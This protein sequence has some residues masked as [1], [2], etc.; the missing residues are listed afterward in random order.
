MASSKPIP[1]GPCE[2]GKVYTKADI[3]CYN[4]DEGLCSTCLSHHKKSKGTRDHKTIDINYK[5]FFQAIKTECDKHDKQLHLYC[6]SHLIP[7]CDECI[8]RNHSKCTGIKSLTSEVEKTNVEKSKESV[9]RDIKSISR[10][11]EKIINKTLSNIK[12]GEQ[13]CESIKESIFKVRENM[14]KHLDRLEK[15][16]CQEADTLYNHEKS[17]ATSFV[18]EIEEKNT[19][20]QAMQDHLQS[21][22]TKTPKLQS[23]LRV[24]QIQQQLQ[25]YQRYAEDIGNDDRADKFDIKMK[26]NDVVENIQ[27]QLESLES[28]G[29][30]AVVKTETPLNRETNVRRNPQ[31]ESRE[32]PKIN[33]I[34]MDIKTSTEMDLKKNISDMICLMDGRVIVAELNGN[35]NLFTSGGKLQKQLPI[36]CGAYSVKQINHKAIA[37]TYPLEKS[38]KI[39]NMENETVIKVITLDKQCYGLSFYNNS[40]AVGLSSNNSLVEG[41]NDN[42]IRI[43]DPEDNTQKSIKVQSTSPLWHLVYCNNRVIYSDYKGNA[44]HCV[45]GS[46]KHIWQYKQDLSGP[47]G[48]STDTC[49]NI[50]VA[51]YNSNRIILISK[52]GTNSKV[53]NSPE[54][55]VE[56][57]RCIC[58]KHN[59]SLVFLCDGHGKYL[60]KFGLSSE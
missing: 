20:L 47:R 22:T 43:I 9:E 55:G 44:V 35:V 2:E 51:D 30:V 45:D 56:K 38:I 41:V 60:A 7:C 21:V 23:F 3:W 14:N 16:L 5:P 37:I 25:T 36:S 58:F 57:P 33:N 4:C 34:S 13:Q 17:T 46:G 24:H 32:Q 54:D 12:T 28:L 40:L 53:L 48:L 1:C 8:S 31:V 49:G 6:P 26:Q 27:S 39:F 19:N 50:I 29:E 59:E 52:D 15:K 18:N 10:L 11:F 42:E